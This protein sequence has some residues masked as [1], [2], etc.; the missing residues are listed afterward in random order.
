MSFPIRHL[1]V[2]QNWSCH[3]C[4]NCCREY[5]VTVTDEEMRRIEQQGWSQRPEFKDLRLFVPYGPFWHRE[6]R[7]NHRTD[8]SC[9]FLDDR[10]LC[11]IHAEFGEQAKPLPCQIY[12]YMLV[13]AGNELRVSV[14]FSC[15][16]AVRNLGRPVADQMEAI[17]HYARKLVP[18]DARP[19]QPPPVR[20]GQKL[21]WPELLRIVA[22]LEQIIAGTGKD[23]T[24]RMIQALAFV[25]LVEQAR[26]DKLHGNRLGELW[27][28]LADASTTELPP[29]VDNLAEIPS[30]ARMLFRLLVAQCA[31]KDLSPH[32]RRGWRG[33]WGLFQAA[34]RFAA[35]RGR[36][37][38][39]QPLFGDVDF[40]EVERPF[41]ELPSEAASILERYYRI[42][43]TG[44]QFFGSTFYDVPLVEGFYGLALTLP[45]ILWIARWL[46]A[47]ARRRQLSTDDV[48]VALTVVDHQFGFANVF[49]FG[50]ARRRVRLLASQGQVERLIAWYS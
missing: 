28:I 27:E 36:I 39:I 20:R 6:Y 38:R 23:L 15:P 19:P 10:G 1:P 50:Y 13:P 31:R 48:I 11:S 16:S 22:T 49:G 8:G 9:I 32:L 46:A 42:K 21:D 29:V 7:L 18:P 4:G 3:Q 43:L 12:P 25:R 45:V 40:A 34:V 37:P 44:L 30:W 26:F 41:G 2:I 17:R 14:R 33:R 47:G 24:Q 35:G 5:F